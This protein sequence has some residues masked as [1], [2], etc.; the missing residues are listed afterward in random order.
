MN[1]IPDICRRSLSDLFLHNGCK[2]SGAE[3]ENLFAVKILPSVFHILHP[4]PDDYKTAVAVA[5][6]PG[7]RAPKIIATGKGHLAERII[8][9]AKEEHIPFYQDDKLAKTLSKLVCVHCDQ[10]SGIFVP[11]FFHQT[12]T[13][14][15]AIFQPD[16]FMLLHQMNIGAASQRGTYSILSGR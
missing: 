7:E 9:K 3:S 12:V 8:E 10:F 11:C 1:A 2:N 6:E 4:F 5:Y 13:P 15:P 14:F 16:L